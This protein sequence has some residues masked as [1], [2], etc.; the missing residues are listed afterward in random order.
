[1]SWTF[2]SARGERDERDETAAALAVRATLEM[3]DQVNGFILKFLIK[4]FE[5]IWERETERVR[6]E[7]TAE[8]FNTRI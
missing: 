6:G 5:G 1:M 2:R 3:S 7:M 8:D 4:V